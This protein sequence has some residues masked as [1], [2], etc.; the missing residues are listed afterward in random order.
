MRKRIAVL[1]EAEYWRENMPPPEPM[2]RSK[3]ELLGI[4]IEVM[5][6]IRDLFKAAIVIGTVLAIFQ[7]IDAVFSAFPRHL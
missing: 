7:I 4:W 3:I 6:D 1:K 5:L 2:Q